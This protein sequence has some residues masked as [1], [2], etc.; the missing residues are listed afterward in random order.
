MNGYMCFFIY[1][2][3]QSIYSTYTIVLEAYFQ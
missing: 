3:T 1:M 2:E